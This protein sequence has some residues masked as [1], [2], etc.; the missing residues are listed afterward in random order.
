VV[1]SLR[2]DKAGLRAVM[3]FDKLC[4]AFKMVQ[5]DEFYLENL[6][7]IKCCFCTGR[8]CFESTYPIRT[9]DMVLQNSVFFWKKL[10]SYNL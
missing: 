5:G 1:V 10:R 4:E 6:L 7:R 2:F 3:G 9:F 8:C